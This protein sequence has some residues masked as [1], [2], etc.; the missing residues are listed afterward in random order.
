MGKGWSFRSNRCQQSRN[1]SFPSAKK[2]NDA[3][4][5]SREKEGRFAFDRAGGLQ[6]ADFRRDFQKRELRTKLRPGAGNDRE[7]V[8]LL[9]TLAVI[10]PSA[11][12]PSITN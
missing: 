5:F 4:Q 2:V 7:E 8:H 6:F 3:I 10:H 1:L 11:I 12:E 9:K